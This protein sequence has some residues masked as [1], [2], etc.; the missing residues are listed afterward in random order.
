[1]HQQRLYRATLVLA[2]LSAPFAM[3]SGC[4]ARVGYYDPGYRDYHYWDDRENRAFRG[5]LSD[6]HE[7][8]RDFRHLTP[9]KQRNYWQWRHGHADTGG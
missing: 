9:D 5:Y 7:E 1:M 6:R 8:Y 2:A 3:S 4:V